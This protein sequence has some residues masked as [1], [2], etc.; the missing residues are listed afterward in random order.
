MIMHDKKNFK[1]QHVEFYRI[2]T[3]VIFIF[4]KPATQ[5]GEQNSCDNTH[6]VATYVIV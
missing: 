2:G 3:A 1:E 6:P 4:K 5:R